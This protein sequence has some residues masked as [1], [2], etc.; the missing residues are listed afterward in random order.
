LIAVERPNKYSAS[1]I[2]LPKRLTTNQGE[3]MWNYILRLSCALA[4]LAVV[5]LSLH[6][7]GKPVGAESMTV[8][9]R[10]IITPSAALRNI[11]WLDINVFRT[12]AVGQA[13][14][15]SA[16]SLLGSPLAIGSLAAGMGSSLA[17]TTETVL[18]DT[19]L[20][21]ILGGATVVVVDSLGRS[22]S[23]GMAYASPTQINHEIPINAFPG[24]ATIIYTNTV[25][26]EISTSIV[27]LSPIAP[28]LFTKSGTGSGIANALVLRKRDGMDIYETPYRIENGQIIPI[29]IDFGPTTDQVFLVLFG[30]GFRFRSSLSATTVMIGGTPLEVIYAG[31]DGGQRVGVEQANVQLPRSLAGRGLV[32]IVMLVD[33]MTSNT[34]QLSFL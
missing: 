28:G 24:P 10:T 1:D 21:T 12:V 6:F 2:L 3:P 34:V 13:T 25:T 9:A 19:S 5:I 23:A 11:G 16:A 26:F 32:D 31:R 8:A 30:T 33:G 22:F 4:A 27:V 7:P 15:V 20:P 14:T 18:D 17:A 29:P